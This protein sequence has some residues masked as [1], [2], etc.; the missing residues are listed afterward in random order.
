[1]ELVSLFTPVKLQED[2][3]IGDEGSLYYNTASFVY[4]L[5]SRGSWISILDENN[6]HTLTSNNITQYGDDST[7]S[8][9][10]TLNESYE[11]NTIYTRSSSNS[12]I[13]INTNNDYPVRIGAEFHIVR[14]GTGKIEFI[15]ASPSI[16]L[17]SPSPIYLTSQWDTMTLLKLDEDTWLVQGEFRDLY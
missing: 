6:I 3:I 9:S 15:S 13:I 8:F 11:N 14:G 1:M 7:V 5:N 4:R 12:F 10:L 2:P 16:K 17:F